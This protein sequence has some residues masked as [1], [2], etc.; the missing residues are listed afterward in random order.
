MDAILNQIELIWWSVFDHSSS[1]QY[2]FANSSGGHRHS[3]CRLGCDVRQMLLAAMKMAGRSWLFTKCRQCK[4]SRR[5]DYLSYVSKLLKTQSQLK[6]DVLAACPNN[7][8]RPVHA[9]RVGPNY[10]PIKLHCYRLLTR[11]A[12]RAQ[13][14]SA[15]APLRMD[16]KIRVNWTC[17]PDWSVCLSDPN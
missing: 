17:I 3:R 4:K 9:P 15:R 11:R 5:K 16:A 2:Y 13:R 12:P 7:V 10:T 1:G 14:V 6:L 8:R